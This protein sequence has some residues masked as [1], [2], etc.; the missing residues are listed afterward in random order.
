M[1]SLK[2]TSF[3]ESKA[4]KLDLLK[5]TIEIYIDSFGMQNEKSERTFLWIWS[6]WENETIKPVSAALAWLEKN[7]NTNY[8]F[9]IKEWRRNNFND[10]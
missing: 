5:R 9:K 7:L 10:I 3:S 1:F 2:A 6:C 4:E 8:Y